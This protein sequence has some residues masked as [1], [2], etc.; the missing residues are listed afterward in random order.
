MGSVALVGV[1]DHMRATSASL[2]RYNMPPT[3]S[4]ISSMAK[5]FA[6]K[7][8]APHKQVGAPILHAY[9]HALVPCATA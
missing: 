2:R 3:P 5:T 4:A 1:V 7:P 6:R 9:A 8:L